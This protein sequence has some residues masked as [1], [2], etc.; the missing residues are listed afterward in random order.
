MRKFIKIGRALDPNIPLDN[1]I[2]VLV[3]LSDPAFQN[4]IWLKCEGPEVDSFD[5]ALF[6]LDDMVVY[7]KY[8]IREKEISIDSKCIREVLRTHAMCNT[9]VR[10]LDDLNFP[11]DWQGWHR[12]L[13]CDPYWSKI[14]EQA[15]YAWSLLELGK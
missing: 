2:S 14:R 8:Q 9:F 15:Q 13:F 11:D 3:T 7:F 10:K 12:S 5:E 4:R 1:L 6:S